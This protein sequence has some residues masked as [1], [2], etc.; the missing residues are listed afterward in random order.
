MWG[1]NEKICLP[2]VTYTRGLRS[3]LEKKEWRKAQ[4]QQ[5]GRLSSAELE[6]E[7]RYPKLMVTLSSSQPR[8]QSRGLHPSIHLPSHSVSV[9][10]QPSLS[11]RLL[12]RPPLLGSK[13]STSYQ[14]TRSLAQDYPFQSYSHSPAGDFPYHPS[15]QDPRS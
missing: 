4:A 3:R 14:P 12:L 6:E 9:E 10:V 1:W 8:T 11:L 7:D 13:P 5:V 2:V 15:H